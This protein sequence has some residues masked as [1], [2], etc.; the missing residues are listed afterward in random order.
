MKLLYTLF[1]LALLASPVQADSITTI[2]LLNRP[3][4]EIIPI[5]K[6]ML[7]TDDVITGR[8]FKLFLRSSPETLAQVKDMIDILDATA[9]ILQI[10]VFQGSDR[11]LRALNIS[12]NVQIESGDASGSIGT[13]SNK[14]AGSISYNTQNASGS[15]NATSTSGRMENNPLQRLRVTEGTEGY[16][17]T[18][19]QIP[20]FS[21]AS[22]IRPGAAAG[23]IEY[24]NVTTGFYVLPR[25]HGDNVSLQVSPFKNSLSKARAGNIETQQA[26]TTIT[27]RIGEWLLIGGVTEQIKRTQSGIGN[28]SS[29]QSSTNAGIWIKADL[30]Q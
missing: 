14:S 29:T 10:S 15:I 7:G 27:G 26:N 18:G 5:I 9:K 12:G 1:G 8:G 25:I 16:I 17:E 4:G 21:G 13:N 28:Y 11:D 19:E 30:T 6:P 24:R 22:W 2:Q 20:Y 3:A 23:D